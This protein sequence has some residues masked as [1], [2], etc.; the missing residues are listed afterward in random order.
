MTLK[1]GRDG[2]NEGKCDNLIRLSKQTP[3]AL[4]SHLFLEGVGTSRKTDVPQLL[5]H[6]GEV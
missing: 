5:C 1:G 3:A 6:S 4:L 2:N